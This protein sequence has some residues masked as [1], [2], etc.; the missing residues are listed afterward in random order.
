MAMRAGPLGGHPILDARVV[1]L[2]GS[3]HS[4]DSNENA[5]HIASSR[6]FKEA[7]QR[8]APLLLEPLMRLEVIIPPG[9]TGEVVSDLGARRGQ[10]L[11]LESTDRHQIV[12]ARVPLSELFGY[13]GAL[14]SRTQG[15]GDFSMTVDCYRPVPAR[16]TE[17]ALS[18]SA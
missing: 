9:Y 8:A 14:R 3:A 4:N 12:R 6:A 15:R 1:L 18:E 11:E 5:F 7:A 13:A 17:R 16:L 2:G 10:V